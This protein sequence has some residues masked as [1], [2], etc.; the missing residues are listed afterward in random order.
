[1]TDDFARQKITVHGIVQGVGFRPFV[2]RLARENNLGGFV[3]N[4]PD[5]VVVEAEGEGADLAA[6]FE[7]LT[8]EAPPLAR[9][10]KVERVELP[11][12]GEKQFRVESTVDRGRVHT[13]IS[14]DMAL[15][16][17]CLAELRDPADRRFGYPFINCTNC[18]PRYTIVRH[19]PYDRVNTS[20]RDFIMC[21]ACQAE[22][23]DPASRRFHAQPNCCPDCGPQLTLHDAAGQLLCRD[24][25]A[26]SRAGEALTA[27]LIVAVKGLGGFH[28][29]VDAKNEE[30]VARLR[31]RKGRE[32]KPL[33]VMVPDA[34][35]ARQLCDL[36]AEEMRALA[37]Q[38]R[39]I[40]L[41]RQRAGHGLARNVAP[42]SDLFGLLLPYAPVH[43][44]L[45]AGKAG[46]LV[47]T[48]ANLS[49]EPLCIDN[50]EA[51]S[52][53]AGIADSFLFHDRD[54]VM[55]CDDSVEIF[56][57]GSMRQVR[58]SRGYAPSPLFLKEGGAPVLGVGGELK[59][60]VCLLHDR[61]AFMSQHIG[62]LK[63]LGAYN[64]FRQSSEHLART[65]AIEPEL[66]VHDLHPEYLS[67]RWAREQATACLAVQ[68]HHA[69]LAACCAENHVEEPVIGLI[70]D[71][72]GYGPDGTIWGGEVLLG[73]AAGY[74]RFASF[75][76]MALP[77]GDAAVQAPWRTAVS[78]LAAAFGR[79][80]PDLPFLAAHDHGPI[81]EMV[82]KQ[83]NSPLTSSCGRLF[84]AVAALSGGRQTIRYE[85]QA[86]IELMQQAG[87][88]GQKPLKFELIEED[89]MLKLSVRSLMRSAAAAVL[90]GRSQAEIGRA[91]HSAMVLA[92]TLLA[93]KARS[94][95]G[96]TTVALSGGVFQNRLLFEGLCRSLAE[97]GFRVITHRDI[98]TND[99]C[100][101][102]GQAVIGR[103]QKRMR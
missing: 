10:E 93:Q 25:A 42:G 57:A 64:F 47:M 74:E 92:L 54:I 100:I 88:L 97:D 79:D 1:M 63:N 72:T 75:E 44:L 62:D 91:F 73:N 26:I 87:S 32:A 99:A 8:R 59:N 29:A 86:A 31:A 27:G 22:Y 34:A 68:H 43:H 17:D 90:A 39:P 46:Y 6:F 13:L 41:A 96:L 82:D 66:I 12:L 30:A 9:I 16:D 37:S 19:I 21:P 71:G 3:T 69:H 95:S 61:Y 84:D 35:A 103:Y 52:R 48:S 38:Q 102:L 5:G 55:R 81:L 4:T 94:V 7:G 49:E 28:L 60:T 85:A 11:V 83:V 67:S 33:A 45:L 40:V 76:K 2:Y 18:G 65:F 15:C 77:G 50:A 101:A 24:G 36:S 98:P 78:Y 70:M 56:L 80:L 51:L 14:P 20:M 58:R 53:L 23:D 89:G